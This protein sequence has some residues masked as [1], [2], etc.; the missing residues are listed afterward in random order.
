MHVEAQVRSSKEE[1][2]DPQPWPSVS[3]MNTVEISA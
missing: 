3:G 1:R 2:P